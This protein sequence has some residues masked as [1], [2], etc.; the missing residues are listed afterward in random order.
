MLEYH[1]ISIFFSGSLALVLD[2]GLKDTAFVVDD[3]EL[4]SI[5]VSS[6]NNHPVGKSLFVRK[7]KT[8]GCV[9]IVLPV[10]SMYSYRSKGEVSQCPIII[11]ATF[12]D[13]DD[14]WTCPTIFARSK[15]LR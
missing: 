5:I 10:P 14:S 2:Y 6:I 4:T 8:H 7:Q 9:Q 13:F 11:L 12:I 1:Q 15:L 3:P